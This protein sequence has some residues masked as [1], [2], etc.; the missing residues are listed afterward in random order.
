VIQEALK[1]GSMNKETIPSDNPQ[2]EERQD[3]RAETIALM[4]LHGYLSHFAPRGRPAEQRMF[5]SEIQLSAEVELACMDEIMDTMTHFYPSPNQETSQQKDPDMSLEENMAMEAMRETPPKKEGMG[6]E[7]KTEE[8]V[9]EVKPM[10]EM[11]WSNIERMVMMGKEEV[12]TENPM[13]GT[14]TEGT[15]NAPT[16]GMM[17]TMTQKN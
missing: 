3:T 15:M 4:E 16:L 6:A 17:K 12:L 14:S 2:E 7:D 10:K 9:T 13:T 5:Q 11:K 1:M 8:V